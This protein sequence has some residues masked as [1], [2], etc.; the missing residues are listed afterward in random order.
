[1]SGTDLLTGSLKTRQPSEWAR[2]QTEDGPTGGVLLKDQ[3]TGRRLPRDRDYWTAGEEG[4]LR[5]QG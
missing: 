5:A 3:P 1:M 2:S 4:I